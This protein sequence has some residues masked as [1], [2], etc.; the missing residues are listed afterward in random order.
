MVNRKLLARKYDAQ[1]RRVIFL[2]LTPNGRSVL[3]NHRAVFE[4][5]A[6]TALGA[7]DD[8]EK[9]LVLKAVHKLLEYF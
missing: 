6:E 8:A 3:A 9:E 4:R 5:L 7:L 2:T 1:D